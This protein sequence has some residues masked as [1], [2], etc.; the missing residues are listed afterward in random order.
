[1]REGRGCTI[2]MAFRVCSS[3]TPMLGWSLAPPG[4][5]DRG[6]FIL[7]MVVGVVEERE[8]KVEV[9]AWEILVLNILPAGAAFRQS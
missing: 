1:M 7:Y 5:L 6:P 8:V 4:R 3:A 2:L 9:E